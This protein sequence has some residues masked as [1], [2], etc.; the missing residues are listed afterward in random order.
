MSQ[1]DVDTVRGAYEAFNRGDIPAVLETF[2]PDIEWVEPGGG[3]A[4]S[5]TF[6]GPDSV[7]QDVFGAIG[8]NFDEFSADADE[9][10]DEGDRV[11]VTGRVHGNAKGGATLDAAFEHDFGMRDGK[12]ARF[13]NNVDREAWAQGWS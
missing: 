12:T 13:E 11:V 9:F 10:K 5:G 6:R 1:Q 7:A 3:N 2:D 8:A 4:P